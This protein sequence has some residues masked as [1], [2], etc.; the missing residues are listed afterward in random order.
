[1]KY[2]FIVFLFYG[3]EANILN[4]LYSELL[5]GNEVQI[6]VLLRKCTCVASEF[7]M[8]KRGRKMMQFL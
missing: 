1:M 8:D 3:N 4:P 5:Y 7:K 2:N 6:H